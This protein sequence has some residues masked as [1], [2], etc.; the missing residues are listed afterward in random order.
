MSQNLSLPHYISIQT[1]IKPNHQL[2]PDSFDPGSTVE[3]L[4]CAGVLEAV[5]VARAGF[6]QR[7]SHAG[8][9]TQYGS[10]AAR[11]ADNIAGNIPS[12]RDLCVTIVGHVSKKMW[13][14]ENDYETPL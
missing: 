12:A 5:R 1:G 6:P 14:I 4:R 8:F 7:F 9:I 3:Q 2:A 13:E 11:E 10:L